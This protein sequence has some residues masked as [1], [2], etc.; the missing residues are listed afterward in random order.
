[1]LRKEFIENNQESNFYVNIAEITELL[2][3]LRGVF[4]GYLFYVWKKNSI[5][6]LDI[7]AKAILE[8]TQCNR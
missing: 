1:M 6:V 2:N 4:L 3:T 5:L 7:L 8:N